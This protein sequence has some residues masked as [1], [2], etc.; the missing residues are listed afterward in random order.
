MPA[1][2]RN[3]ST[4]PSCCRLSLAQTNPS[5]TASQSGP[6]REKGSTRVSRDQGGPAG[7]TQPSIAHISSRAAEQ[8]VHDV[9]HGVRVTKHHGDQIYSVRAKL[10]ETYDTMELDAAQNS[11]SLARPRS[12]PVELGSHGFMPGILV[13]KGKSQ[14]AREGN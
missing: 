4:F 11:A 1:N 10:E 6:E 5:Q 7:G 8:Y 14:G 9:M 12:Y 13:P 2:K 3:L